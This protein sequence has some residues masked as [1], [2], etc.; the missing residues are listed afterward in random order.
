M[1][2]F[3]K[4]LLTVNATSWM[5][6]IYGINKQIV[7]WK[8]PS[9]ICNLLLFSLPVLL[10]FISIKTLSFWGRDSL[11][12]CQDFSLADNEFLPTYLG[13]FFV[14]LSVSNHTTMVYLYLI[15]FMFTFLSQTQ[16]F[17]PS[18]MLFGYH[19]YYVL[20]ERGTRVLV[21]TKGVIRNKEDISFD[22]LTRINNTTYF[23]WKE[24]NK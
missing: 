11:G 21:I 19:Y 16:Y 22:N 17:N 3:F 24:K 13:Y 8:M 10:A 4:F 12:G 5:F 15:V 14:S 20:T 6:V 18:F 23:H 1:N 9:F 2:L 7:F